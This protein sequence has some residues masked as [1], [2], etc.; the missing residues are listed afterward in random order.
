M[1]RAAEP[2][3]RPV[4]TVLHASS[5]LLRALGR[6]DLADRMDVAE[7]RLTRSARVICVV[8]EYKQG[9]SSLANGLLAEDVCPVDDDIAT[10]AITVIHA[11]EEPG[12]VVWQRSEAGL[13]TRE[14]PIAEL[15]TWVTEDGNPGNGLG[16]E[17]IDVGLPHP[18]L[19]QG[20]VLVDTPGMGGL[21]AG[22]A[23]ATLAFLPFADGL[24]LVSDASS[25]LSRPELELLERAVQRC[26]TVV[27]ALTK[28]DLYPHWRRQIETARERLLASGMEDVP[29]VAVSSTLRRH[30]LAQGDP[31]VNE[32]SGYPELLRELQRAIIEPS[33]RAAQSRALAEVEATL[34]PLL[35][36]VKTQLEALDAGADAG[37]SG[38]AEARARLD[39]L[40]GPASR[41]STV[42]GDEMTEMSNRIN[43]EMRSA[44]RTLQRDAEV[45]LEKASRAEAWASLTREVQE[46][47]AAVLADA[48]LALHDG[49]RE[50]AER[51]AELLHAPPG[52]S[53]PA[54]ELELPIGDV[55]L[56]NGGALRSAIGLPMTVLGGVQSG[57]LL[58]GTLNRL[59]PASLAAILVAN[60]VV[61]G[62]GLA[63]GGQRAL[64]ARKRSVAT[65]RHEARLAL[66][67]MLDDLQ[68]EGGNQIAALL[69][70]TQ[71]NL[72]DHCADLHT[73]SVRTEMELITRLQEDER[74]TERERRDRC[75]MLEQAAAELEQ[76]LELA[77]TLG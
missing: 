51:L 68:F 65:R 28:V 12:A 11:A 25:D 27:I 71:R 77:E 76:L 52:M 21:G 22:H 4:L 62:A 26:P 67:Q 49:A 60:P 58:L 1:E 35:D 17:R 72:R 24:I 5:A 13:V 36:G 16:V 63:M 70:T 8:G 59:L 9:K 34:R 29:V 66:R 47:A 3:E 23:A 30:A 50:I 42:L 56:S 44:I 38:L 20:V 53:L 6:P 74:R 45:R 55:A 37:G 15:R 10:A 14:I 69:R 18:V 41:W 19:E 48:V 33:E 54:T 46:Q 31:D 57:M 39:D 61:I 32:E 2:L 64:E 73:A 40:Q 7:L 75:E 43:H